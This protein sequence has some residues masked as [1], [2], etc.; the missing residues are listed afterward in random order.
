MNIHEIKKHLRPY[1]I[2][3]KR[4][5]TISHAF[6]SA[7]AP[8][9]LYDDARVR[10]AIRALGQDPDASL[11]CVYCDEPAETWDHVLATVAKG[12]FSGAGHV[13]ANLVPC[14][15]PCN[16]RKGNKDWRTFVAGRDEPVAKR[17]LRLK[18]IGA[19]LAA[20]DREATLADA[21]EDFAAYQAIRGRILELM[22]EADVLA[23]RIR[24]STTR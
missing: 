21:G 19:H 3:A 7:I 17:E 15:K 11:H 5:T 13:L 20:I 18:R 4:R 12:E 9:E 2:L 24:S 1:S 8:V 10:R 23:A 14:C 16:S 6:A 22:A